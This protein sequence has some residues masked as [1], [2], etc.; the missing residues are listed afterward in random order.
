MIVDARSVPEGETIETDVCIIGAGIAGITMARE[1]IA[2]PFRVCLLESGGFEPDKVTQSL[3]WGEDVGHP[4]YPLDTH[5][6]RCFGGTAHRWH[7]ALGNFRLGVRLRP[8]D[9]I[10]FEKR[11][12]V[13]YSGWP[14]RKTHLDPYYERAHK[15][16][17]IGPYTYDVERWADPEKAP[18]LPLDGRVKTTIFQFGPRDPFIGEYRDEIGRSGNIT[19]F[20]YANAVELETN[21]TAQTVTR[22]RVACL[23]GRQFWVSAKVFILAAGGIEIPRLLLLSN[24]VQS[25]GLGNQHDLV[26]RFFM[27]HPHLWS[28]FYVPAG[29]EIFRRVTLY[30]IHAVNGVTIMAKL[31]LLEE[32]LR[33]EKLLN[34]CV[35]IHPAAKPRR[36]R[37][38]RVETR[39]VNSLKVL[40]KAARRGQWP[41]ELSRHLRNIL[42]DVDHIAQAGFRSV[43]SRLDKALGKHKAPKVE[44]FRLNHMSEQAPNPNSRVTLIPEKDALGRPRVQLN[45]QLSPIDIHTIVRAQEIISE[46][47]RRAGLGYLHIELHGTTPP[48]DLHGG[49][50]QMGTTRMH[51]DPRHGVVDENCRV[52]GVSNLFIAGPSVFPT[53][54]YANPVLTFVALA[55]RLTDHVKELMAQSRL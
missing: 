26:G 46:E 9:E 12:W 27:E 20:L 31:T 24:K 30:R 25:A 14:F 2:Q 55:L 3:Y 16:L 41:K 13:P 35:S 29:Q 47:L 48:P 19:T 44:V 33:R 36:L 43:Q 5:G 42:A 28:G 15:V 18:P 17:Q 34:Y 22:I 7:A 1:F 10:D 38:P 54:G 40:H 32:V 52:H 23:G 21:D 50:H 49:Y 45:W 39:G 6:A 51:T 53:V 8:L 37:Y 11:D 4:Y